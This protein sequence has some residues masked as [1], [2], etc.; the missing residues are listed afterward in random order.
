MGARWRRVGWAVA[1]VTK[2]VYYTGIGKHAGEERG[3]DMAFSHTNTQG[4]TYYLH[5][6]TRKLKSGKEQKL[7]F[8]AKTERAGALEEIPEGYEVTET[9]NGLPVLKR[10]QQ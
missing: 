10:A 2:G 3:R 8:F 9:R 1:P 6:T 5:A 4:K 7:Y